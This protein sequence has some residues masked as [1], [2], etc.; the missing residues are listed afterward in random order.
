[1]KNND[2]RVRGES[3]RA[4]EFWLVL[5]K[6]D[7]RKWPRSGKMI[8]AGC[9]NARTAFSDDILIAS[10]TVESSVTDVMPGRSEL[11]TAH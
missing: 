5:K 2:T 9:F 6:E 11:L 7:V 1:L 3:Y 8:L 4:R 10:A